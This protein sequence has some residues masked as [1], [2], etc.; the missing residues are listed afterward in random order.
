MARL[1]SLLMKVTKASRQV[2]LFSDRSIAFTSGI[3]SVMMVSTYG[4][5]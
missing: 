1:D 2:S 3:W 4:T 5:R